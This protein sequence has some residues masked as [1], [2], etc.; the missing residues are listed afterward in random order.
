[1]SWEELILKNK[2]RTNSLFEATP[3]TFPSSIA[4][5]VRLND[6][7]FKSYSLITANI[8]E[9]KKQTNVFPIAPMPVQ[10]E[11]PDRAK[12]KSAA[13]RPAPK[14]HR[15][16][17]NYCTLTGHNA[18]VMAVAVDPTNEFFITGSTDRML[19]IWDLAK[20][21]LRMTLTGH[22]GAI[23]DLKISNRSP[24]L[25]SCCDAKCVYCWDL[26]RNAIVRDFHGHLSGV[27]CLSLHPS[28]DLFVT[29][30]R[31][32]SA[33]VWDIRTRQSVFVL[34]GHDMTIFD[35]HVQENQ[36]NVITGSADSTIRTWDLRY[37]GKCT[38][39]LT[40]HKKGIRALAAHPTE[41]SF[42]S[43]SRDSIFQWNGENSTMFKQFAEH[44]SIINSC[45]INESDVLVTAADDGTIQFY[46]W[47]S[48]ECFQKTRTIQHPGSLES[49]CGIFDVA[50]DMTGTRM[51]TC[52]ADKTVKLWREYD[53]NGNT[54]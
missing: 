36:P 45:A 18:W 47:G 21:E 31:D 34:E 11:R 40:R 14:P 42:V 35:V 9:A 26:T 32:S 12:E 15:Q 52:E 50:F 19:K 22:I 54:Y 25:F 44:P 29:G 38:A 3:F 33:R 23:H 43:A 13:N 16:W 46:D 2:N 7:K 28:I 53:E 27:Y 51:I 1:M 48:G 8:P 30:S 20:L 37:G 49:E 4:R 6:K 10:D 39:T 5:D 17:Y 24:Y 41:W